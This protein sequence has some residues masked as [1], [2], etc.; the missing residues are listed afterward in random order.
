MAHTDSE[1]LLQLL[2]EH[3]A[4]Y[5]IFMLDRDGYA[6]TWNVGVKRL[7]GYEES[8]FLG[9]H[10][11]AFF[12]ADEQ[13]GADREIETATAAGRSEDERWQVRKDGTERWISGVLTARR[14]PSGN[15]S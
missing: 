10:F 2:I 14:D 12:R 8:E 13:D 7:L 9:L 5:A 1:E 4:D 11:R 3:V 6:R 15:L